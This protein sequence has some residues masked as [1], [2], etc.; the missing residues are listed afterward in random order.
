LVLA[1]GQLGNLRSGRDRR[2]FFCRDYQRV[3][4]RRVFPREKAAWL[5]GGIRYRLSEKT[6]RYYIQYLFPET[7]R[8]MQLFLQSCGGQCPENEL[9]RKFYDKFRNECVLHFQTEEVEEFPYILELNE[10]VGK[11]E[12][13]SRFLKNMVI[14]HCVILKKSISTSMIR[15]L[16]W[17][18]SS[19]CICAQLRSECREYL[20][21]KF[22]PI[23]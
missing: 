5:I 14:F 4:L 2:K 23:C 17:K 13:K 6:H 11:G 10:V 18:I 21:G 20:A 1:T 22:V 12:G 19:S 7:D 8:L 9:V 16:T 3:P 15:Y